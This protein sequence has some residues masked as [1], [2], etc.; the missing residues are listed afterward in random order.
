MDDKHLL[1][2]IASNPQSSG[3]KPII[4]GLRISVE[5]VLGLLAQGVSIDEVLDYPALEREDIQACLACACAAIAHEFLDDVE[6][7]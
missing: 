4:R 6:V 3:G 7:G 5:P 2:R 1:A